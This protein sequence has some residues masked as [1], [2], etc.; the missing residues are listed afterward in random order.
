V[1]SRPVDTRERILDAAGALLRRH[2]LAKTTVVDVAR[3]LG[4]SHANIY[5]HFASKAALRA[6]VAERWLKSIS[7][8]LE[9]FVLKKGPAGERLEG[10]AVALAAAKRRKVQTDPE[11]FAAYHALA[12]E[13]EEAVAHHVAT[14]RRQV[15]QIIGDGAA[16]REL[17]VKDS[18]AA[19]SAFFDATLRFH[20]PHHVQA[21]PGASEKEIRT[22]VR[23]VL[24]G[25]RA[26][27]V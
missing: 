22:L 27:A 13:S 23:L 3:A 6:A 16:R 15:E 4:M 20:H 10:W 17:K 5:R 9:V 14:L 2:G 21:G 24:A 19:A 1:S 18:G 8:P 26:G 7:D 12:E 25:M 11:M